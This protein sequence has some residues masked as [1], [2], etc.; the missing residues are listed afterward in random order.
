MQASACKVHRKHALHYDDLKT[1][2][3]SRLIKA[4][5]QYIRGAD[6]SQSAQR[7]KRV[8]IL[9]QLRSSDI[10][11]SYRISYFY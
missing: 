11:I 4:D 9:A 3:L 1:E 8:G 2:T 7:D 5:K 6:A 10:S